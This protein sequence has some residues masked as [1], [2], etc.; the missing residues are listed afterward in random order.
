[1]NL[2]IDTVDLYRTIRRKYGPEKR[3]NYEKIREVF[4]GYN[5][6]VA[7]VSKLKA[8]RFIYNLQC[9]GFEVVSKDPKIIGK[10]IQ[11]SF[12][13]EL[14]IEALRSNEDIVIGCSHLDIEPL[15][16]TL[17]DMGR[18]TTVFGVSVP[19]HF[20]YCA[21]IYTIGEDLICASKN[22]EN[23]DTTK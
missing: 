8:D 19:N 10:S 22:F 3:L 6:A 15:L 20:R 18:K 21:D 11:I 5:K 2:L 23:D 17:K 13:V 4:P 14:T 12:S 7:F 1:M 16:R 9:F